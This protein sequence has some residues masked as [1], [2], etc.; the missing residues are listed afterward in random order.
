[1][2]PRTRRVLLPLLAAFVAVDGHAQSPGAELR[3]DIGAVDKSADPCADFYQYACGG[4]LSRNPIPPDRS[5][6]AVFQQMRAVNEE[7]VKAILEGAAKKEGDPSSSEQKIGDDYAS[8]MDESTIDAKGLQPLRPELERIDAIETPDALAEGVARLHR[9]GA[10]PLFQFYADQSLEDAT[11]VIAYLDQSGLNLPAPGDYTSMDPEMVG[12]R[13]QYRAHLQAVFELVGQG[14]QQA[15]ASADDVLAIETALAQASLTPVERRDRRAW[16]HEMTL[17]GLRRLA[18]SFPWERYFRA[19]GLV[20]TG[21]MNV[22][23]PRYVQAIEGLMSRTPP[24]AWRSYLAWDLVRLATPMLPTR[25]R[26]ADFG[27]YRRTLYD[28][29][30]E[31]SRAEQCGEQTSRHLGE[32]VG[33]IYVRLYFPSSSRER[34]LALV[35]RLR[36]AMQED[37][38]ALPWLGARTRREALQ[39]LALL[40][41][42][43]GSPEHWRDYSGLRVTRGDALG[44]ALRAQEFEFGRQVAKIGRPVDRGEFYELPQGVGG[45]H[46]NPLNVVVFTA[47]IL[48]PPFFDPRM[49]DA[50]TFGLAGGVIGHELTHAF[51]DKGHLFDGEG[52]LRDWW[53]PEDA[54]GYDERAACFVRQYSGYAAADD[55]KVDGELT[56]GENIAD[57]GG[58][59]LAYRAFEAEA[60]PRTLIDGHSPE[61]RFFLGWAQWRCMNVTRKTAAVWARTDNHSPGRWRVNGVVSNMPAFARAYGCRAGDPMVR[62]EPCRVW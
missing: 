1:M 32:A 3:F 23:V 10:D 58:L 62:P 31:P 21:T 46:D 12:R 18:P 28:V 35:Q 37:I 16:Y 57:N 51:D 30:E 9:L 33:E 48:Q 43:I 11:Q 34:V 47:G 17:P 29:K 50:I 4:W 42:M 54:K 19:V 5:Y 15:T 22:A 24:R 39:K 45:Y 8:C 44:N 56:L 55:I 59:Q 38:Q 49:D 13:S 36:R 26:R 2:R 41:T 60:R 25:F 40:R 14:A 53:T 20:P 6:W 27:F 7:R 52:N 61:Q